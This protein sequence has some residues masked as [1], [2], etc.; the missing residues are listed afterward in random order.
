MCARACMCVCVSVCLCVCIAHM[1]IQ[2]ERVLWECTFNIFYLQIGGG[3]LKNLYLFRIVKN[4]GNS[5]RP[6]SIPKSQ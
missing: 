5:G 2:I 1:Y 6:I 3:V 4:I